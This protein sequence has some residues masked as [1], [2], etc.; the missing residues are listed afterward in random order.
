MMQELFDEINDYIGASQ[1]KPV[2]DYA[3]VTS[4]TTTSP[5]SATTNEDD[6]DHRPDF[7]VPYQAAMSH[8]S[9]SVASKEDN[10]V[11]DLLEDID[12]AMRADNDT[13]STTMHTV[14]FVESEVDESQSPL[15]LDPPY[16]DQ[17]CECYKCKSTVTRDMLHTTQPGPPQ[18]TK[19]MSLIPPSV[20]NSDQH[21]PLRRPRSSSS[22]ANLV[23]TSKLAQ[24]A[25]MVKQTLNSTPRD[26]LSLRPSPSSSISA[27]KTYQQPSAASAMDPPALPAHHFA[28]PTSTANLDHRSSLVSSSAMALAIDTNMATTID[29]LLHPPTMPPTLTPTDPTTPTSLLH[30]PLAQ[31]FGPVTPTDP[32]T[33]SSSLPLPMPTPRPYAPMLPDHRQGEPHV[34]PLRTKTVKTIAAHPDRVRAYNEAYQHCLQAK[35]DMVPWVKKQINKGKPD[36]LQL[37]TPVLRKSPSKSLFSLFKRRSHSRL[38]PLVML[39]SDLGSDQQPNDSATPQDLLGPDAT[40][41]Q[42]FQTPNAFSPLSSLNSSQSQQPTHWHT[43]AKDLMQHQPYPDVDSHL[44]S[45][46]VP[47]TSASTPNPT[48]S[49]LSPLYQLEALRPSPSA[50]L[51]S[52]ESTKELALHKWR[53]QS[54]SPIAS[55]LDPPARSLSPSSITSMEELQQ[56]H[57][58]VA[59][60]LRKSPSNT[61][62]R[63]Q[64]S[65]QITHQHLGKTPILRKTASNASLRSQASHHDPPSQQLLGVTPLLRKTTSNTSLHS[66]YS[67]SPISIL[68][69]TEQAQRKKKAASPASSRGPPPSSRLAT[70]KSVTKASSQLDLRQQYRHAAPRS[71][72]VSPLPRMAE[73]DS[74]LYL[75]PDRRPSR[76][77]RSPSPSSQYHSQ[78]SSRR[79]GRHPSSSSLSSGWLDPPARNR[80]PSRPPT[81][82]RVRSQEFYSVANSA[83]PASVCPLP[84]MARPRRS[85]TGPAVSRLYEAPPPPP[86][87]GH[88]F[89]EQRHVRRQPSANRLAWNG[90]SPQYSQDPALDDLCAFFHH[91]PRH[92][93]VKYLQ[94][95]KG[96]FYLAKDMCMEDIMIHGI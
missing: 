93:L 52:V 82:H 42:I 58:G 14:M 11:A 96:D 89:H 43:S 56:Q 50:S 81:L 31:H 95:A 29:P 72:S 51:V 10:L 1:V 67:D 28:A 61:S 34:H 21:Q 54:L 77:S 17:L 76:P 60:Q 19:R 30:Q 49:P 2:D 3:T 41:S 48:P 36:L 75:Q 44:S 86:R 22:F 35:T 91:L 27:T 62:L 40:Q 13:A 94:D 70:K 64:N 45:D 16:H 92:V 8:D 59:P 65:Q 37:Y 18:V 20:S 74:A 79:P 85:W 73:G 23:S 9:H 80:S 69:K 26:L 68:K 53:P 63:S 46:I 88:G 24:I 78:S 71:R 84:P 6:D 4:P 57:L 5:M 83:A 47:H 25:G 12:Q 32:I 15:A 7:E 38:G 90:R 66:Q 33:P 55:S 39:N 87:Q